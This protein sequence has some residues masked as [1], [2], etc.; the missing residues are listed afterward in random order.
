MIKILKL[1]LSVPY[2]KLEREL[3]TIT[4]QFLQRDLEIKFHNENTQKR[5]FQFRVTTTL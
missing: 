4:L 3:N 1:Y 2:T 5:L